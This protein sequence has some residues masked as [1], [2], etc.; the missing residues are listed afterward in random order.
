MT[1]VSFVRIFTT[2]GRPVAVI[3]MR[4]ESLI[5]GQL[6]HIGSVRFHDED[7]LLAFVGRKRQIVSVRR[8]FGSR[9]RQVASAFSQGNHVIDF[10]RADIERRLQYVELGK[11]LYVDEPAAIA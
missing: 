7:I 8:N 9:P 11:V 4:F 6:H 5:V 2:W 1:V 10:Q 3:R